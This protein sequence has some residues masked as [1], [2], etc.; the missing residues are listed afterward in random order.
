[1]A[2][3]VNRLICESPA[4]K[5]ADVAMS[6]AYFRLLKSNPRGQIH[7]L[8]IASQ[9][10][11]LAARQQQPDI[12][13]PAGG[14]D[15]RRAEIAIL[16]TEINDRH[17]NLTP[18][19]QDQ[20]LAPL[21]MQI[22]AQRKFAAQFSGGRFAGYTTECFF[23]PR[24]SGAGGYACT[25]TESLQNGSRLCSSTIEW[26]GGRVFE[27][28]RVADIVAGRRKTIARCDTNDKTAQQCPEPE[29]SHADD[30]AP[31]VGW[32]FSPD[33][34]VSRAD[35]KP[36][37]KLDPDFPSEHGMADK[38]WMQQC[39]SDPAYP[40]RVLESPTSRQQ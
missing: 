19:L 28:R 32:N 30:S 16:L 17:H 37:T 40:P 39:L 7:A 9:R 23:T 12:L 36:A 6:R 3:P 25:G 33:K 21:L 35:G 11:W 27:D 4:L 15:E 31:D 22:E 20:G 5:A 29:A 10:R 34:D 18:K 2:K 24:L 38:D 8:L 14:G 13:A 26:T 1:M